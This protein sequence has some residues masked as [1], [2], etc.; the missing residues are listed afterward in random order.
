MLSLLLAVTLAAASPKVAS[1]EWNVV[2][3]KPELARFYA[4]NLAQALR[5][6][7]LED[8]MKLILPAA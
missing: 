1:P 3:V 7:G 5:Q 4:D 2:D 6:A 8:Q